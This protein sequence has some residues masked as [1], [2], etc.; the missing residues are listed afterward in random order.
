[1]E[2]SQDE[3]IADALNIHETE[4]CGGSPCA[5][6]VKLADRLGRGGIV[7]R[8]H[9]LA[10]PGFRRGNGHGRGRQVSTSATERQLDLIR[11]LAAEGDYLSLGDTQ[12]KLV[13]DVCTGTVISK[14]SASDLISAL[15]VTVPADTH[16]LRPEFLPAEPKA[17]DNQIAFVKRLAD[18]RGRTVSEDALRALNRSEASELIDG[19][20]QVKPQPKAAPATTGQVEPGLYRNA[21]GVIVKAYKARQHDGIL[22]ARLDVTAEKPWIYLGMAHRFVTDEFTRMTLDEA[23]EFGKTPIDGHFYCCQC[24]TELTDPNSQDAGIGPVC[25][26]KV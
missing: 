8:G 20:L 17:S 21:K 9:E 24:G 23:I 10:T 13:E 7:K 12:R 11:K 26:T 18:E 3:M 16:S 4:H 22:A 1:M 25:A 15:M 14:R 5:T 2:L 19:L 6:A